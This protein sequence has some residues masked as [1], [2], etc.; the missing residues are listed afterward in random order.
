LKTKSK[1]FQK[2]WWL[3]R[4]SLI[5]RDEDNFAERFRLAYVPWQMGI[6]SLGLIVL[7]FMGGF[8]IGS[9]LFSQ[10]KYVGG[11]GEF[12]RELISLNQSVDSLSQVIET[13]NKYI[14]NVRKIFGD[15]VRS[16]KDSAKIAKSLPKASKKGD[17]VNIDRLDK[18]DI[19]LR[20]EMEKNNGAMAGMG[21]KT[22]NIKD[23]FLFSP[24]KG[25]VTDKYSQKNNHYGVDIVAGK[26]APIKSIAEGTVIIASWTDDTGY[27]ITVQHKAELIS[28]Y[29]HC[30]VLLKK[31]GDFVRAGEIIAI[32]GNTGELTTGPHLHF[33]LWHQGNPINPEKMIAF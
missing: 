24:L 16:L 29:K 10:T 3:R 14:D 6:I 5:I 11:D 13:Q 18:S 23:V 9:L 33:E 26:D 4:L 1:F 19:K 8:L 32:I 12:A 15:D 27:V 28:V 17:S 25:I 31:S 22:E 7:L 21:T 30:S 20:E 2:D